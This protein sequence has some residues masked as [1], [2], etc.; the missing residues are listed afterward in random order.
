MGVRLL[1]TACVLACVL[2]ESGPNLVCPQGTAQLLKTG[3]FT[4]T[5]L[6][7]EEH[8]FRILTEGEIQRRTTTCT[9]RSAYPFY[10]E[11]T[12]LTTISYITSTYP[13]INTLQ[14]DATIVGA[15]SEPAIPGNAAFQQLKLNTNPNISFAPATST[16]NPRLMTDRLRR[17]LDILANLITSTWGSDV[18]LHVQSAWLNASSPQPNSPRDA[19]AKPLIMFGGRAAFVTARSISQN[20]LANDP[21]NMLELAR[22]AFTA[23]LDF[24]W[25]MTA[26][27]TTT[28]T[29]PILYVAVVPDGCSTPTDIAFV[30]DGSRNA[31]AAAFQTQKDFVSR[32]SSYYSVGQNSTRVA[33][34]VYDGP[35]VSNFSTYPGVVG[36]PPGTYFSV[37]EGYNI[38]KI[39]N[40]SEV[41]CTCSV[42][43]CRGAFV[44]PSGPGCRRGKFSLVTNGCVDSTN[45]T[46][47][48]DP[49]SFYPKDCVDCFCPP[50][51]EWQQSDSARVVTSFAD[52][53]NLSSLQQTLQ[54]LAF[55]AGQ[56]HMSVGL[57]VLRPLFAN[58]SRAVPRVVV[59]F[60]N[61]PANFNF[62][63][64]ASAAALK[65][66]GARIFVVCGGKGC[67][68][69]EI[70]PVVSSPITTH[71]FTIGAEFT[72]SALGDI[73]RQSVCAAQDMIGSGSQNVT[74]PAATARYFS[75]LCPIDTP[76]LYL[77][78]SDPASS[79]I[80]YISRLTP[81]PSSA[82][83]E[84]TITLSPTPT[85]VAINRLNG[86]LLLPVYFTLAS[87]AATTVALTLDQAIFSA[88][89]LSVNLFENATVGTVVAAPNTVPA[90]S[91]NASF[92][93][94]LE[95]SPLFN[96]TTDGRI[97]LARP[98]PPF[99]AT[100]GVY[101]LTLT[102]ID[103]AQPCFQGRTQVTVTLRAITAR[104]PVWQQTIYSATIDVPVLTPPGGWRSR[105]SIGQVLVTFRATSTDGVAAPTFVFANTTAFTA[106][107]T[108]T[109]AGTLVQSQAITYQSAVASGAA[110]NP[111]TGDAVF[112]LWV[113]AVGALGLPSSS[114]A[115]V[116]LT[117]PNATQSPFINAS[118]LALLV[119]DN[120][121][122]NTLIGNISV[123][124]PLNRAFACLLP[125]NS[126]AANLF[127]AVV[128]AQGCSL[129]LT[130]DITSVC[131]R[132][133]FTLTVLDPAT[134]RAQDVSVSVAVVKDNPQPPTFSASL[135]SVALA[136]SQPANT[137]LLAPTI[138]ASDGCGFACSYVGPSYAGLVG[139]NLTL[140]A[141]VPQG[142]TNFVA[143]I[144]ASDGALLSSAQ[145]NVSVYQGCAPST[146]SPGFAC[147]PTPVNCRCIGNATPPCAQD[148]CAT[149]N[150][151]CLNGGRCVNSATG[152]SCACIGKVTGARCETVPNVCASL[153]CL[154]NGQCVA[155]ASVPGGP[156][157]D[158]YCQCDDGFFGA[159]CQSIDHS[160]DL[161]VVTTCPA[162]TLCTPVASVPNGPLDKAECRCPLGHCL[163]G[164]RCS[165]APA[166]ITC[167]CPLPYYGY[168]CQNRADNLTDACAASPAPC[169]PAS[170]CSTVLSVTGQASAV[171]SCAP[172]Y[173][174]SDCRTVDAS[175]NACA[176]SPCGSNGRCQR[177]RDSTGRWTDYT[178]ACNAPFS[179]RNCTL[180]SANCN[181]LTG[182]GYCVPSLT[183]GSCVCYP[184][185]FAVDCGGFDPA[186]DLCLAEPC[187]R[188]TCNWATPTI[189]LTVTPAGYTC[190]CESDW[191]GQ[192]CS[193]FT[194]PCTNGGLCEGETAACNCS[195]ARAQG[196]CWT[197]AQC[198]IPTQ[199]PLP[200]IV[201]T[202]T[203]ASGSS[204]GLIGGVVVGV[205]LLLA[206]LALVLVIIRRRRKSPAAT[207]QG[208][209]HAI[210]NPLYMDQSSNSIYDSQVARAPT[211]TMMQRMSNTTYALS[212]RARL[213]SAG[214]SNPIYGL[215]ENMYTSAADAS[216]ADL[217][218]GGARGVY[219][220][221]PRGA[222]TGSKG[223][224]SDIKAADL[225]AGYMD[226]APGPDADGDYSELRELPAAMRAGAVYDVAQSGDGSGYSEVPAGQRENPYD[227]VSNGPRA[228]GTAKAGGYY[229][230]AGMG[231]APPAAV[232]DTV[233]SN[234]GY[235]EVPGRGK[236]SYLDV[237]PRKQED[238]GYLPVT[239][240]APGVAASV[241]RDGGYLP[242]THATPGAG[243]SVD[244]D[245][246][247]LPVT[248]A[249]P[250]AAVSVDRDG[251]YLPVTHAPAP[252][253]KDGEYMTVGQRPTSSRS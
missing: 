80:L 184:G 104:R 159:T 28:P 16:S 216:Y 226:V 203:A 103:P 194:C 190:A 88:P 40:A 147:S 6:K 230:L 30:L 23:G 123:F 91:Y 151:T 214:A 196:A 148:F 132:T 27:T 86:T 182:N 242:V 128:T 240:A 42:G 52:T 81:R 111:A 150:L 201:E 32:V 197:G 66:L 162:N 56:S 53:T 137:L 105:R 72:V 238:G 10:I 140:L 165:V 204:A 20:A 82:D 234:T 84:Q 174:G 154:P 161:C 210:E 136:T 2:A 118:S 236:D 37:E 213:A 227:E 251:G 54:G 133:N 117:V 73:L 131:L 119:R 241:D 22:M 102:A 43:L 191:S 100:T 11:Y 17:R 90:G 87:N 59:L 96:V 143:T 24:I 44:V 61:G 212:P 249:A 93:F 163:N 211:G 224:Y 202:S 152:A 237:T 124:N 83:A 94:T 77:T 71:L 95:G 192:N 183:G 177:A 57:D 120:T 232:Y 46:T 193:V 225:S 200:P 5:V 50:G 250:G 229:T 121:P 246:G 189:G 170:N 125:E 85:R 235:S 41:F 7:D 253:A 33:V 180:S 221:L 172:G 198:Q 158:G 185:F 130:G 155:T 169:G 188:G 112:S 173:I 178:C 13:S 26:P 65:A 38:S 108:L 109:S 171:C 206:L 134:N 244:R 99:N 19:R 138:R 116:T 179:G 186:L 245:G 101:V 114:P 146:C 153:Q 107:F 175:A 239:H 9:S 47:C 69:P 231:G 97:L 157:D 252:D 243:A 168:Q 187:V 164:G 68:R 62:E 1:V 76:V 3:N 21:C 39:P 18:Q 207:E 78:A 215:D 126:I 106:W 55:P 29:P 149:S 113:N 233:P 60:V 70:D 35:D 166:G 144:T 135:F 160:A 228:L 129:R 92:V 74:Q 248:R 223:V 145:V 4:S 209:G 98:L 25:L 36:C 89:A 205:V 75:Y 110:T 127:S 34:A 141:P 195:F 63:P 8:G 247:Y 220:D 122:R 217:P 139:C 15:L 12:P 49:S 199:C 45:T 115:V 208:A 218:V 58:S 219:D 48:I 142:V 181:C 51:R 31:N 67:F 176:S 14:S 64:L 79:T 222:A 156:L 167:T